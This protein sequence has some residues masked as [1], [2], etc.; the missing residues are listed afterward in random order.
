MAWAEDLA[1]E[2]SVF[3]VPVVDSPMT[4]ASTED[5]EAT[6]EADT[7]IGLVDMLRIRDR[8]STIEMVT[9]HMLTEIGRTGLF[10]VNLYLDLT[11]NFSALTDGGMLT[12]KEDPLIT[13]EIASETNREAR[14]EVCSSNILCNNL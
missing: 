8:I 1:I 10:K 5:E 9:S 14:A 2:A 13:E 3:R 4:V 7:E 12:L 11:R 6:E